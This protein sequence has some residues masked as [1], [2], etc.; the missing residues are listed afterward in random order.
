MASNKELFQQGLANFSAQVDQLAQTLAVENAK[1]QVKQIRESQDLGEDEKED[2][3]RQTASALATELVG[4]GA[5]GQRA[6]TA[7]AGLQPEPDPKPQT[8]QEAFIRGTP[9]QRQ[10]GAALIGQQRRQQ[11]AELQRELEEKQRELFQGSNEKALDAQKQFTEKFAKTELGNLD[12][13]SSIEANLQKGTVAA[14]NAAR[15]G[16]AKLAGEAGRLTDRDI[17][18][19]APGQSI[20]R[21]LKRNISILASG[22]I[23][24][25]D[26]QE[27]LN[28]TRTLEKA[29][30]EKLNRKAETFS[31]ARA[32]RIQGISAK[33]LENDLKTLTDTALESKKEK[34]AQPQQNQTTRQPSPQSGVFREDQSRQQRQ[35]QGTGKGTPTATG[36]SEKAGWKGL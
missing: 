3:I 10:R 5:S 16:L 18:R 24:E 22:E 23:P 9:E 29:A 31:K 34:S 26:R 36:Q 30:R 7:A 27:L 4:A 1:N 15:T 32:R 25:A 19:L 2:Q 17:E 35:N 6:Q 21:R 20:P 11:Q 28:L 8:A 12:Q 33:D 14:F 13:V